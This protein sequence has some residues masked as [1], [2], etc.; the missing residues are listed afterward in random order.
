VAR[1]LGL[2]EMYRDAGLPVNR[3]ILRLPATWQGIQAARQLEAAGIA[4]QVFLVYRWAA[5]RLDWGRDGQRLGRELAEG[6]VGQLGWWRRGIEQPGG[7]PAG[8]PQA[9][10]PCTQAIAV[11]ACPAPRRPAAAVLEEPARDDGD[12]TGE[13]P[14]PAPP[15]VTPCALV[16]RPMPMPTA[17]TTSGSRLSRPPLVDGGC[18]CCCSCCCCCC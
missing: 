1:G 11:L 13:L 14:A 17:R 6:H 16:Q 5:G 2:V 7:Q 15:A 8:H 18:R 10:Q 3:V 12:C 9:A 4:T